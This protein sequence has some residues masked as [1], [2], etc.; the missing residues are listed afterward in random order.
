MAALLRSSRVLSRFLSSA[1]CFSTSSVVSPAKLCSVY[2]QQ[3]VA[4][5]FV[6]KRL[7]ASQAASP[8]AAA[9]ED[10][11]SSLQSRLHSLDRIL[12][13][14]DNEVRR[15]GRVSRRDVD[16]VF[17]E[18]KRI[19]SVTSSQGLLLVRSCGSFLRE[20]SPEQR[21]QLV[22]RVWSTLQELKCPM[23]VSH[24]NAL[25]QVYL[26]N[27]LKFSPTEFLA[28]MEKAGI[29][30]NRVTY[31]RLIHRFCQEGDISG[32]SKILEHMKSQDLPINEKVFNSLVMGHSRANDMENAKNIL[33]VMRNAHLEPTADT[34]FALLRGHAERGDAESMNKVLQ[35]LERNEVFLL[36]DHYLGLVNVLACS[37]HKHHVDQVLDKTR[38]LAGYTQDCINTCMELLALGHDDVAHKVFLTMTSRLENHG[39]FFVSQLVRSGAPLEKIVHYCNDFKSRG[40]NTRALIRCTEVALQNK[41]AE[42]ALGLINEMHKQELPVRH[43]YFYP[44]LLSKSGNDDGVYAV[45]KSMMDLELEPNYETL[46][47]FALPALD[48]SDPERVVGKLKGIGMSVGAIV[49]PLVYHY[50]ETGKAKLALSTAEQFPVNLVPSL[51]VPAMVNCF[52]ESNDAVTLVKLLSLVGEGPTPTTASRKRTDWAGRFVLDCLSNKAALP[53]EVV[54]WL[55]PELA[56]NDVKIGQA[57]AETL[58]ARYGKNLSSSILDMLDKISTEMLDESDTL[59]PG[60]IP[61]QNDMTI[62]ELEGHLVELKNKGM[63]TRGALRRLLLLHCR[64][65]NLD[66]AM[67]IAEQLKKEGSPFTGAMHA[68]LL[69]L[70]VSAGD[71]DKALEH[72]KLVYEV[73]PNFRLDDHKVL[74][75]ASLMISKGR[76]E[77]GLRL[78]EESFAA[79]GVRESPENLQRNVFRLLNA[80]SQHGTPEQ[81]QQA[82]DLAVVK[83]KFAPPSTLVLGPLVRC[84]LLRDDL[85]QALSAFETCAKA[86]KHTP[87]KN[88]LSR[89]FIEKEDSESLQRVVDISTEVHGEM[90]TLYDLMSYFLE[91]GHVRQAQKILETP[92]LRARHQRLDQICETF[93]LRD[94]ITELEHLVQI[95]KDLFDVNRD[96]M[97]FFLLRA[98]ASVND[99]GRALDVW[100]KMQ[101]ENVQPSA[102]TLRFLAAL[103]RKE[104]QPLPFE[105]PPE[106]DD[107]AGEFGRRSFEA[108]GSARGSARGLARGAASRGVSLESL[109]ARDV[110]RALDEWQRLA[111]SDA[112]LSHRDTSLLIEALILKERIK[113]ALRVTEELLSRGLHPL[114]R[115]LKF[116]LLRL[117]T[118]GEADKMEALRPQ[119]PDQ[120]VRSVSFD[121]LVC[122]AY[123]NCGRFEELLALMEKDPA[124]YKT[125][126]PTGGILGVLQD[127]PELEDRIRALAKSYADN[128]EFLPPMNAVWMTRVMREDYEGANKI[129]Q[130]YPQL[131]EKLMFANLLRVSREK[132]KEE[133]ARYVVDTVT[134]TPAYSPEAKGLVCGNLINVL[135]ACEKLDEALQELETARTKHGLQ[136]TDFRVS[137][138][139]TLKAELTSAGKQVPFE[140]PEARVRRRRSKEDSSSSSDDSSDE[141]EATASR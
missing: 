103:L 97:Y 9:Q 11:A 17:A 85:A 104:G 14:V 95:T 75:L 38:R 90:N 91:C 57:A 63:N 18:V 110:D 84:H 31:Q 40:F 70:F 93:L 118:L 67:E 139:Q 48:M 3:A 130:E 27:E 21:T 30:A 116:L 8:A 66:R 108:R 121:N 123:V 77:E 25:L 2:K 134:S 100:T 39:N 32:A 115:V 15:T 49:N 6:S 111:D 65:R 81:T 41:K 51:L 140:V 26:E 101:E 136:L 72:H 79:H 117:A 112:A 34:Y 80:V 71:L 74:N 62:E 35:E 131:K 12:Y 122:N 127:K 135:V 59:S 16:D 64:Y 120:L 22:D 106:E 78:V 5:P 4:R 24:Y 124:A 141:D 68:Q 88:E 55:V 107:P 105:V 61:S 56:A 133:M 129:L 52:R 128:H 92:G 98:Y 94:M 114:P 125:R 113:D 83:C 7:L 82:F 44:V 137:T 20:E 76:F 58:R 86:Y 23:D 69:D 19:G 126:F 109:V 50:L 45:L 28:T 119:L 89:R 29:Q 1:R 132:R 53:S 138:L 10:D 46:G 96:A 102:R 87:M 13:R 43:H 33:D 60:A 42:L 73:E 54:T 36:D 99:V 37:G 47:E